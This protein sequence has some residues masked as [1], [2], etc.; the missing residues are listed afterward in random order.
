MLV[1]YLYDELDAP[2]RAAF[3]AALA[4]HPDL[5][6][7]VDAHLR[8]RQAAARLPQ[9]PLPEGLFTGVLAEASRAAAAAAPPRASLLQRLFAAISRPPIAM[10]A[11]ACLLVG[12]GIVALQQPSFDLDDPDRQ[13]LPASVAAEV[14]AEPVADAER[15]EAVS[16]GMGYLEAAA[17]ELSREDEAAADLGEPFAVDLV[18]DGELSLEGHGAAGRWDPGSGEEDSAAKVAERTATTTPPRHTRAER[19]PAVAGLRSQAEEPAMGGGL[20]LQAGFGD[21]SLDVE[22]SGA[23]SAAPPRR[24]APS[25]AAPRAR[26]AEPAQAPPAET[27]APSPEPAPR[28]EVA[29]DRDD[30]VEEESLADDRRESVRRLQGPERAEE[31]ARI[32]QLDRLEALWRRY[33][34]HL[35]AE[36]WSEAAAVLAEL[37]QVPGQE[38]AIRRAEAEFAERR[39]SAPER[40]IQDVVPAS[41]R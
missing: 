28:D 23:R 5:R 14:G 30:A 22:S 20:G 16:E 9:I 8:T 2:E 34:E 39:Q 26:G 40:T 1:D 27:R 25:A 10:A 32:A 33:R 12:V 37:R 19:A 38:E 29:P 15:E 31:D 13:R 6:A 36:R 41:D 4:D 17:R 7:E 35:A 3:E 24:P 21:A 18:L 11:V